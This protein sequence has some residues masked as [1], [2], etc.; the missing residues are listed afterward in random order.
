ML[1]PIASESKYKKDLP[2][3]LLIFWEGSL[4]KG[5]LNGNPIKKKDSF[6]NAGVRGIDLECYLDIADNKTPYGTVHARNQKET[7][8]L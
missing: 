3:D 7:R 4:G 5:Q 2:V 6:E 1:R 8:R